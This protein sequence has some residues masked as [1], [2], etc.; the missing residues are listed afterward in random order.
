MGVHDSDISNGSPVFGFRPVLAFRRATLNVPKPW[1]F[2]ASPLFK[3]PVISSRIP[4]TH[5]SASIFAR[6]RRSDNFSIRS[7]WSC[8]SCF[9]R[10]CPLAIVLATQLGHDPTVQD[11]AQRAAV[12]VNLRK[13]LA[14]RLSLEPTIGEAR[15]NRSSHF[16]NGSRIAR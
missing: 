15:Q 13:A 11:I 6:P 1:S 3:H 14:A 7:A 9:I 12:A 5:F 2:R 10:V 8:H 16:S 4:S